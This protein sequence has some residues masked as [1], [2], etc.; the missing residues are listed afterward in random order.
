MKLY[1]LWFWRW[2]VLSVVLFLV[3]CR[4]TLPTLSPLGTQL[5]VVAREG[6]QRH[7]LR[8]ESETAVRTDIFELDGSDVTIE[9]CV[10]V[11]LLS[12]SLQWQITDPEGRQIRDSGA[13][14][15]KTP[16]RAGYCFEA[17]PG[18]W[19][20]ETELVDASGDYAVAWRT[21]S[22]DADVAD[23]L[24]DFEALSNP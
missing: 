11:V 12:G 4:T 17:V 14:T 5:S 18:T 2:V 21:L 1:R 15:D 9:L 7:H 16:Y 19:I 10:R 23:Y 20:F 6:P 22:P 3:G 8:F 13:V 24:L